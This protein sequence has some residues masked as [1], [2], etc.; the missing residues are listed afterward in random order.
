ML[1]FPNRQN[2]VGG[3]DSSVNT[4]Q[5]VVSLVVRGAVNGVP[6]DL[7]GSA[8][9]ETGG[10]Q[11]SA[12]VRSNVALPEGFDLGLISYVLIT[13]QPSLSRNSPG[14]DNPFIRTGGAYA[15]ERTLNLGQRGELRTVYE[16]FQRGLGHLEARFHVEGSVQVPPLKRIMPTVETW[17]PVGIGEHHGQFPLVW[18]SESGKYI[19]GRTETVYRLPGGE[20][21]TAVNYRYIQIEIRVNGLQLHQNERIVVYPEGSFSA[22]FAAQSPMA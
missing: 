17:T 16:V 3:K 2:Q 12:D 20:T 11:I 13:G 18:E 8:S 7:N 6:L 22:V 14:A 21:M 15:A 4:P 9:G 19:S 1:Y 5:V 10:G